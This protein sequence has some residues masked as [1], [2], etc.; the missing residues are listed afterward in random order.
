MTI[1]QEFLPG[2]RTWLMSNNV[3]VECKLYQVCIVLTQDKA[4]S[5]RYTQRQVAFPSLDFH[6]TDIVYLTKQELLNSL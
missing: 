1:E 3:P 4:T 2:I 6:V 5:V